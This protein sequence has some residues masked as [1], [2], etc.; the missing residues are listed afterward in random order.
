MSEYVTFGNTFEAIHSPIQ[1]H[2]IDFI[3]EEEF[4]SNSSFLDFFIQLALVNQQDAGI[5]SN[6]PI[7]RAA[8]NWSCQ[9]V[10][11]VTTETG[12]SDV[13][14]IY[15]SVDPVLSKVAILIEDKIRAG[16]QHAQAERYRERGQ[17]GAGRYWQSYWTCLIAPQKYPGNSSDFDARIPL[18]QLQEFF[19]RQS[20]PRS[21]FK[22]GVI[23]R[24]LM[25][26]AT[27][28]LQKRDEVMTNFR[29]FYAGQAQTHFEGTGVHWDAP[30]EAWWGDTWFNFR[31][32]EL[33]A[34]A[35]I[36]HK[37]FV[38]KAD[39]G[40]VHLSIPN[41]DANVLKALLDKA[42]EVGRIEV[43]QTGKSASLQLDVAPIRSYEASTNAQ[44][45]LILSDAFQAVDDLL[46]FWNQ[47]GLLLRK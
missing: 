21:V 20:D 39:R 22:A 7:L 6:T 44:N 41:M 27:T 34:G 30:R 38:K 36:V 17:A 10:R 13:L 12:E 1:E 9:A 5:N 29:S 40:L 2:H 25:H 24:A 32:K 35:Y 16:F 43:A 15:R 23:E 4:A 11:S 46:R 3:L 8:E 33:P 18:E 26:F 14:V 19:E 42:E 47:N 37:T 45:E 31:S 28:G